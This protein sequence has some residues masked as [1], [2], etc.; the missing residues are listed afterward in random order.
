MWPGPWQPLC[1]SPHRLEGVG[2]NFNLRGVPTAL[3]YHLLSSPAKGL[4]G[5]WPSPTFL[6]LVRGRVRPEEW[7]WPPRVCWV[8]PG[9]CVGV[10][11]GGKAQLTLPF[12]RQDLGQP[13]PAFLP[14]GPPRP[15]S[16][17][18]VKLPALGLYPCTP[19]GLEC[20]S[21]PFSDPRSPSDDTSPERPALMTLAGT[22]LPLP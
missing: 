14:P 3:C 10:G 11:G 5:G 4:V 21:L 12:V 13:G 8:L 7:G 2:V 6:P 16:A 20:S 1:S 19:L 18:P 9:R 15:L 22:A 17:L